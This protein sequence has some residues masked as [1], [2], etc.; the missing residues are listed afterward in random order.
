MTDENT[1]DETGIIK[2]VGEL[3]AGDHALSAGSDS[4]AHR[5]DAAVKMSENN[6]YAIDGLANIVCRDTQRIDRLEQNDEGM[7]QAIREI[8]NRLALHE[9]SETISSKQARNLGREVNRRVYKLIGAS[10]RNGRVAEESKRVS[11]VYSP[12]FHSML[13]NALKDKFEVD[14]H[15]DIRATQYEEAVNYV[16][17]W[18]PADGIDATKREAEGNWEANHPGHSVREFLGSLF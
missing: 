17:S 1:T 10:K 3:A 13:W 5:L 11:K 16:R 4:D 6:V 12:L 7:G 14:H 9:Q 15:S 8:K 18:E 2:T